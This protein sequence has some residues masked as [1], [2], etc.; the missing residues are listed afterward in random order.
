ML[1]EQQTH[2]LFL[3]MMPPKMHKGIVTRAQM[4]KMTTMVPKG[5][6]WV[7]CKSRQCIQASTCLI[8]TAVQLLSIP[9]VY[10]SL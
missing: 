8:R 6:A 1:T 4:T 2:L 3:P 9:N 10:S 7:D 5:N